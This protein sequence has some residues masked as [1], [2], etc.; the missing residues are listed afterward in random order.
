M[1]FKKFMTA[2]GAKH[3]IFEQLA[4][5]GKA[6]SS[7]NRL[8]ILEF[9]AQGEK[10]V[11]ALAKTAGLSVANT[12]Q[13][14]QHLRLAGLVTTRKEGQHVFYRLADD[15]VID[16]LNLLRKIA[17]KNLAEMEQIINAY[18]KLKDDL[19]PVEA[20]ELLNR[21]HEGAVT[22]LDV[23]PNDEYQAG[24]IEGAVNVPLNKLEKYVKNLDSKKEIVAYCRGTYCVLSFEAVERLRKLGFQVRRFEAG[25][26]EWKKAGLPVDK[27]MD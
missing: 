25:Y 9:L 23:R 7:A 14:L 17:E 1:F 27:G 12:S 24:H 2:A 21:I 26:P 20:N 16:L 10:S 8:E 15:N 4:R 11:E 19:E 3:G 22:V 5:I 6:T 18:F 13:H